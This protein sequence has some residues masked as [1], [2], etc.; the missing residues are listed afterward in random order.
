MSEYNLTG[1]KAV[2]VHVDAEISTRLSECSNKINSHRAAADRFQIEAHCYGT[3]P[4]R[5]Y[6]MHPDIAGGPREH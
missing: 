4:D 6:E 5:M 2:S 1:A 3:Q